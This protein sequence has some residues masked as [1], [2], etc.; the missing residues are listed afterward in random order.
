MVRGCGALPGLMG[1]GAGGA[2]EAGVRDAGFRDSGRPG[3]RRRGEKRGGF[4]AFAFCGVCGDSALSP[5]SPAGSR[6]RCVLAFAPPPGTP[7]PPARPAPAR[8]SAFLPPLGRAVWGRRAGPERVGPA[9]SCGSCSVSLIFLGFLRF[10]VRLRRAQAGDEQGARR[11]P[12]T[13][14][15]GPQPEADAPRAS[16]GAQTALLGK[17]LPSGTVRSALGRRARSEPS[18][19]SCEPRGRGV[20][21]GCGAEGPAGA[22][23]SLVAAIPCPA[24]EE[25]TPFSCVI[26]ASH[27]GA[28]HSAAWFPRRALRGAAR[29]S[30]NP[31][32]GGAGRAPVGKQALSGALA[33]ASVQHATPFRR[34]TERAST[35]WQNGSRG[36]GRSRLPAQEGARRGT[37]SLDPG[38]MT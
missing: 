32:A 17:R 35:G 36:R 34:V 18:D 2:A 19:G 23:G 25:R 12:R 10:S 14:G 38:I 7:R 6:R 13:P 5:T 11:G 28:A 26:P 16:P 21:R 37:R 3:R 20:R 9:G 8:R 4:G 31:R 27:S 22:R 30:W 24:G 33:G 1:R 15:P 29:C